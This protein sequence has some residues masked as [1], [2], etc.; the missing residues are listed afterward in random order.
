MADLARGRFPRV[1][2]CRLF[3]TLENIFVVFSILVFSRA[4]VFSLLDAGNLD[5]V[6]GLNTNGEEPPVISQPKIFWLYLS[7]YLGTGLLILPRIHMVIRALLAER[8]VLLLLV[9]AALSCL[10]STD[11]R[12]SLMKAIALTACSLFGVY[13]AIRYNTRQQLQLLAAAFSIIM[14]ASVFVAIFVPQI[15]VMHGIHE[16]LWCGVFLHK[17]A[18][19]GFML[20]AGTVF[21]LLTTQVSKIRFLYHAA[22]WLALFLLTMSCAKSSLLSWMILFTALGVYFAWHLRPKM[23]AIALVSIVLALSSFLVQYQYK[24]MPPILLA[25]VSASAAESIGASSSG[26]QLTAAFEAA[27]SDAPP[28]AFDATGASRV[29]LW[30]HLWDKIRERPW[31][32]YGVG[33]FWRGMQGPSAD[34]WKLVQW[35]TPGGHNGFIDLWLD[36][37]VIGLGLLILSIAVA[38]TAG[39]TPLVKGAIDL[40]L[41][42][43]VVT[44]LG[45]CLTK[46]AEGGLFGANILTWILF[47]TAV[48]NVQKQC[49]KRISPLPRPHQSTG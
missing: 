13:L 23:A 47:V 36:L 37:G 49:A 43:P 4:L 18:L 17:N 24:V 27:Q 32:G 44:M 46:I 11:P 16:G 19:G 30:G 34:I 48:I 39:V 5:S 38:L 33:G 15:G 42:F 20:L 14:I 2:Q 29:Q 40:D 41:L 25:Q 6:G 7:I 22:F 26:A 28:G 3:L 21:F 35:E 12:E 45:L 1:L 8:Y 31:L 10:W 9:L